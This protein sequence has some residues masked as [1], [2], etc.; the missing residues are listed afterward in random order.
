MMRQTSI[1]N[2]RSK[3][4]RIKNI[5]QICIL[6]VMF[7][8][9]LYQLKHSY[10]KKKGL[11]EHKSRISDN[12]IDMDSEFVGLGRKALPHDHSIF[13]H[14]KVSDKDKETEEIDRGEDGESHR[15]MDDEEAKDI[16]EDGIDELDNEQ[17]DDQDDQERGDEEAED[18]D[19]TVNEEEKDDQIEEAEFL[20]DQ[21][22]EDD[23]TQDAHEKSYKNDDAS[24]S[25][26]QDQVNGTEIS[27]IGVDEDQQKNNEKDV[28][29]EGKT[30]RS[31]A[32]NDDNNSTITD[33]ITLEKVTNHN[34]SLTASRSSGTTMEQEI[35]P[36]NQTKEGNL[37]TEGTSDIQVKLQTVPQL[38]TNANE[39]VKTDNPPSLANE[40]LNRSIGNAQNATMSL[41]TPVEADS[42]LKSIFEDKHNKNTTSALENVVKDS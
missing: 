12:A 22:P 2:Q 14:D 18:G 6:T 42:S 29:T 40:I 28:E 7:F 19:D 15:R 10:D 32:T 35:S 41:Q 4:L 27:D 16:P 21:D 38:A 8:W 20:D 1:R 13:T 30:G 3:G 24:S 34:D 31:N 33:V 5:L 9:L 23:S 36:I 17:E 11:D 37:L 39:T 26:R 25:V